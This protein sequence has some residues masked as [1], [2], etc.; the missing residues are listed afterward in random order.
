MKD[1][2]LNYNV[3]LGEDILHELGIVFNSEN[4]TVTWQEVSIL[5]KPPDCT[6]KE[7]FVIKESYPVKQATKRIKHI[8]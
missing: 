4:K 6:A 2:L 1:K 7:F 5:I 8:F 3:H